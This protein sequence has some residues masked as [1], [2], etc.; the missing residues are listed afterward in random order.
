MKNALITLDE[1]FGS[2]SAFSSILQALSE[3]KWCGGIYSNL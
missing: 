2:E 1:I 3:S